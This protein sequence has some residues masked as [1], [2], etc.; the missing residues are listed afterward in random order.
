FSTGA[1]GLGRFAGVFVAFAGTTLGLVRTDNTLGLY[2]FWELT[3]LF[4]YL[5]IGHS[6][7][8]KGARR[9]AMQ[10]IIAQTFGGLAMLGGFITR[11]EI[12][13][14]SYSLATLLANPPRGTAVTIAVVL[15]LIGAL[16]KSAQI[17]F[18]FWLPS[19]MAAPTPVSAYLHAAAM[20]KAG[21]YL[22]AR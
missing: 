8:G 16:S 12:D 7:D 19:A 14:G 3:T 1:Q 6:H 10:A 2:V 22:V 4:S 9:S 18:H 11:G 21:V 5:L 13:G 17:P 20:V 15:I